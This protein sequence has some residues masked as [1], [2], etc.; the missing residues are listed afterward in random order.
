MINPKKGDIRKK[1]GCLVR[2][3]SC[4]EGYVTYS[5]KSCYPQVMPVIQWNQLKNLP[6]QMR[7]V[8]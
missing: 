3:I 2:C 8:A 7:M 5:M 1:D 4:G 6:A